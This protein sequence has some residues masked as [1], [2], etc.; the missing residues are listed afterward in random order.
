[1]SNKRKRRPTQQTRSKPRHAASQT[2]PS[3]DWV[4]WGLWAGG[5][6]LIVALIFWIISDQPESVDIPQNAVAPAGVEYFPVPSANHVEGPVAYPQSPPVGG[7]HAPTPLWQNC[8]YYDEPIGN[9]NAVHSLEHGVVWVT[10]QPDLAQSEVD[11]LRPLANE[12]KI[13]VSPYLGLEDPVVL[14]SWGAQQ[15]FQSADD[16]EIRDFISALRNQSPE[17]NAGCQSGVGD[18][19]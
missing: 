14:S 10:Y 4:K 6:L 5:G 13:I 9:E 7:D 15:R 11:K 19:A 16:P 18:P 1:M 3:F 12:Q 17:P 2:G 8:G